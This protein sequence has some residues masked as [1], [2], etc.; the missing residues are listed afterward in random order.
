[1]EDFENKPELNMSLDEIIS[2]QK[3]NRQTVR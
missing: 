1:M 3:K 2:N